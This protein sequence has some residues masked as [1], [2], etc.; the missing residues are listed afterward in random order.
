MNKEK[1]C[2]RGNELQFIAF[3]TDQEKFIGERFERWREPLN[4]SNRDEAAWMAS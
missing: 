3:E 1:S 4:C 2:K